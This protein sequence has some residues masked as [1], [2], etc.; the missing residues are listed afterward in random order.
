MK[1]SASNTNLR[2]PYTEAAITTK[3]FSYFNYGVFGCGADD[4]YSMFDDWYESLDIA[5]MNQTHHPLRCEEIGALPGPGSPLGAL[6]DS[7][8]GGFTEEDAILLVAVRR[9]AAGDEGDWAGWSGAS[10]AAEA[11]GSGKFQSAVMHRCVDDDAAFSHVLKANLGALDDE[12]IA[13]A[14]TAAAAALE[15][16][17]SVR[18]CKLDPGLKA[19]LVSKAQPNE[20]KTCFQLEPGL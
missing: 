1:P 11:A 13:G 16:A 2:P 8:G 3:P 4:I 18:R 17:G 19:P 12:Q 14:A 9:G 7:A 5:H 15:G 10:A 6:D 20:D